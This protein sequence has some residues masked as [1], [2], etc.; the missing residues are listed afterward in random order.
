MNFS[1]DTKQKI[2]KDMCD[3]IKCATVSYQDDSLVDFSQFD[4]FKKL[5]KSRFPTIYKQEVFSVGKTGIVH[6]IK[7]TDLSSEK[8][9]QVLMA[10]YDVV[11]G[12]QE[13]WDF[14]A[15]AGDIVTTD[16]G[17]FIR[18]RGTLDT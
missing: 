10:H 7:G 17:D 4:N 9:A 2:I 16:D 13:E 12:V 8:K 11:P 5:L 18:G 3:M 14:P 15:F 6:K 1:P